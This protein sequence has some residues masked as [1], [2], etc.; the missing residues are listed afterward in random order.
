MPTYRVISKFAL[1]MSWIS[2]DLLIQHASWPSTNYMF[3][4]TFLTTYGVLG[5]PFSLQLRAL[6]AGM[7]SSDCVVFYPITR[8]QAMTLVLHLRIWNVSSTR[9][10]VD[11]GRQ[12]NPINM[13]RLAQRSSRFWARTWTFNGAWV[14]WTSPDQSLV[15][16]STFDF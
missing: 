2:G 8:L 11:G 13:S 9:L 6:N 12:L 14:G 3:F 7:Q 10:A 4:R 1:T 15:C 5:P 16:L